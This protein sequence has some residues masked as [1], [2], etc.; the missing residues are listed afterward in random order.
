MKRKI[1]K[2]GSATMTISLPATWIK[3]FNL[4]VGD[5]LEIDEV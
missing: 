4:K 1:V 3:K 5:E 2:Q